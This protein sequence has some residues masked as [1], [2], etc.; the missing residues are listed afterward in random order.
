MAWTAHSGCSKCAHKQPAQKPAHGCCHSEEPLRCHEEP[1]A[2]TE[3]AAGNC[4]TVTIETLDTAQ[5]LPVGVQKLT[6]DF[7]SAFA[8]YHPV[9]LFIATAATA[10]ATAHSSPPPLPNEKYRHHSYLAQW[11]L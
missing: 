1:T 8:L 2:P 4:C 9:D 6:P 5:D 7:Y 10:L 3:Q 11:R